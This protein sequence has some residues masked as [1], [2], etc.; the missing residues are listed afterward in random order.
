MPGLDNNP[1]W[2]ICNDRQGYI[3]L[4]DS[5]R[6]TS[7]SVWAHVTISGP[8]VRPTFNAK[9]DEMATWKSG[10]F[11]ATWATRNTSFALL[12]KLIRL[13]ADGRDS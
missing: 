3:G 9:P 11:S 10:S 1:E 7:S 13:E 8:L 12:E 4:T 5:D 2:R 6:R